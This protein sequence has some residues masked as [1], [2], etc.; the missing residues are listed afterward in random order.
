MGDDPVPQER[1]GDLF[2]RAQD[3]EHALSAFRVRLRSEPHNA[4]ALAG[5]GYAAFEL[6]RYPLAQRY[7]QAATTYDP[8]DA[9][10]AERLK[11]TEMVLRMDPFRRQ[12]SASERSRIVIEAFATAG[13]RLKGCA[14]PPPKSTAPRTAASQPN[15]SD[16]W[17]TMNPKITEG[18]LRGNPELVDSAMDLVFRI[19]RQTNTLCGTPTGADLALLL[20]AKLHEGT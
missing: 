19:E 8:K 10:S 13:Q 15:L 3:Y 9:P 11:T 4:A 12:I 14:M 16:E 1:I 5:A 7:L 6:N 17:A 2:L 20:I 18:R